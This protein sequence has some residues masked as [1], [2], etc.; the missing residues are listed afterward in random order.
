ML[1]AGGWPACPMHPA[2]RGASQTSSPSAGV[3]HR[4][5]VQLAE[6]G[7]YIS[8]ALRPQWPAPTAWVGRSRVLRG[9][10]PV[11]STA[12]APGRSRR[13]L[14]SHRAA[15]HPTFFCRRIALSTIFFFTIGAGFLA[16]GATG[17][18]R[19]G[20]GCGAEGT[21]AE[22][23]SPARD[24]ERNILKGGPCGLPAGDREPFP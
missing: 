10:V 6:V 2:D 5:R 12:L 15:W 3:K 17:R 16:G 24:R 19:L 1:A 7:G 23:S 9:A 18:P 14:P 13:G 8:G 20:R 21:P 11:G 22:P 4:S